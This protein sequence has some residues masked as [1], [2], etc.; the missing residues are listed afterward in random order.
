MRN[1]YKKIYNFCI[2]RPGK[3]ILVGIDHTLLVDGASDGEKTDLLCDTLNKLKLKLN[4]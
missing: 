2:A 3:E 4:K 1:N